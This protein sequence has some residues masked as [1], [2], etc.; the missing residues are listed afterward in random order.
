[1]SKRK[2]SSAVVT[3]ERSRRPKRPRC[4]LLVLGM[5]RSG[6]SALS[7]VLAKL[8]ATP[9]RSLMEGNEHNPRGYWESKPLVILHD[10]ILQSAGSHWSDWSKFNPD[11]FESPASAGFEERLEKLIADEYGGSEFFSIKDPRISRFLPF[12]LQ[13]LDKQGVVPKAIVPVRHPEEVIQSLHRRDHFGRRKGQLLWLRHILD[14]ELASRG[15]QRAFLRYE[16]LLADWKSTMR[17]VGA[18]LEIAWPRWS[19]EAD[20]EITDFLSFDLR[21]NRVDEIREMEGSVLD[22][23]VGRTYAIIAGFADGSPQDEQAFGELDG[24]RLEFDRTAAI[25][26]PVVREHGLG[27]EEERSRIRARMQG[28][29][30]EA[31]N[32]AAAAEAALIEMEK[33]AV[34][35]EGDAKSRAGR[36]LQQQA[37]HDKLELRMAEQ[38]DRYRLSETE[39]KA[40]L[41]VA[42]MRQE[43]YRASMET[44]LKEYE[45]LE[46]ELASLRSERDGLSAS[47]LE[48]FHELAAIVQRMEVQRREC[49]EVEVRASNLQ[50]E[51]D[52]L[53]SERDDLV[54]AAR[55]QERVQAALEEAK[56]EQER[57]QAALEEARAKLE[58]VVTEKSKLHAERNSME[59]RVNALSFEL[60]TANSKLDEVLRSNTWKIGSPFR[61]VRRLLGGAGASSRA[62]WDDDVSKIRSSG[63]FDEQ[64]YL[65]QNP[66]VAALGL[67]PVHHYLAHG[68]REGRDPSP[69]FSTVAYYQEHPEV[70]AGTH[71]ALLHYLAHGD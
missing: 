47:L 32:K 40:G 69:G 25:Y 59:Q 65:A 57:V 28:E 66:D 8:G 61:V 22:D 20:T 12:W 37:D 46:T 52:V 38:T 10:T 35:A 51:L 5:H 29:I 48:R 24:I 3:K 56:R 45:E 50:S 64:W 15:V 63:L 21:H 44:R 23:W 54:A 27:E 62:S 71:N 2:V 16:D 49:D 18:S 6:T 67:D 34:R 36:L 43:E 30:E 60:Q 31:R 58:L 33:R 14:A 42:Q 9:P 70:P 1:M 55:E 17:K 41:M 11:W 7:G 26:A 13:A 39:L 4:A 19:A 53:R 68:C